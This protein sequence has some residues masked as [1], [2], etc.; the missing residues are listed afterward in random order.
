MTLRQASNRALILNALTR[1]GDAWRNRK[2]AEVS[3]HD[4]TGIDARPWSNEKLADFLASEGW[5]W[6]DVLK[7]NS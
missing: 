4:S 1:S 5:S 7:A 2:M 6:N 3:V